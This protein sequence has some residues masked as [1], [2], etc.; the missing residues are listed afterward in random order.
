MTHVRGG[1]GLEGFVRH[2][3]SL[4]GT[5]L[6]PFWTSTDHQRGAQIF[7][8]HCVVCHGKDGTGG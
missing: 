8:A 1:F 7:Q 2:G 3:F 5:V 6:N 4:E